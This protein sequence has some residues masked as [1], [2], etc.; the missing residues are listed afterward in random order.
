MGLIFILYF[1]VLT[2]AAF[3][4]KMEQR[5]AKLL[6]RS[7][8]LD[9][10]LWGLFALSAL[11]KA[12][13]GFLGSKLR[14]FAMIFFFLDLVT[15]FFIVVGLYFLLDTIDRNVYMG[16]GH[17]VLIDCTCMFI[18]SIMFTLTTFLKMKKT[19]N[20]FFVGFGILVVVDISSIKLIEIIWVSNPLF[21]GQIIS[22]ALI[23]AII[24]LYL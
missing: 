14:S 7:L 15:S 3:F 16:Y 20:S 19:I 8:R 11:L 1:F 6:Y 17:F 2:S 10:S 21:A 18:M 4:V 5:V 9:K 22:I 23:H 24:A 13:M 12:L